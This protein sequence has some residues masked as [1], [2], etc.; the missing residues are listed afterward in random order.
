MEN[1]LTS[2][3]QLF[4]SPEIL[5]DGRNIVEFLEPTKPEPQIVIT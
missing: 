3:S 5:D 2:V 1:E 4:E